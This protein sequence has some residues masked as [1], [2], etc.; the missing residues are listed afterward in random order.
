MKS[1]RITELVADWV[2]EN[3]RKNDKIMFSFLCTLCESLLKNMFE[4]S[5]VKLKKVR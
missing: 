2:S 5:F 1:A 3:M 4:C